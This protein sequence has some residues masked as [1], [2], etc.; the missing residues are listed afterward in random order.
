MASIIRIKRSAVSG[1]PAVLA[2][3]ELAYSSLSD[4]GSNGGDRL[5]IGT[6]TE[7]NGNAV[8]HVIIGGKYF[9]D[10]VDAATNSN[11]NSTLV[12]RDAS[13]N[14]S[15]G[16][17]TANL[18]GNAST[19]TAWETS[20]SITLSGDVTGTVSGVN[21][22]G[23]ISISTTIAADSVA[24]G[25]DTTGQYASTV[26]VS[27]NGLSATTPNA[28]DS[29]AYTITSNAT[30]ANT[31]NTIVFR[32]ASG[33]FTAGTITAALNGNATTVTNGVYTTDTGSVTN[34]MLAGS[35]SDSKLS[36]ITTAGKVANSATTATNSNTAST[37]VARDASGNFAAGT[38]TATFS[39]SLTGNADTASAWVTA[40][41]L[42]LTGDASATLTGVN[43]SGNVSATLTLATVNSNTGTFGSATAIPVITVNGKGLITAVSTTSIDNIPTTLSIA[44]TSGTD[45]VN[46]IN[47]T[48]TF[49]GGTGVTTAVTNNQVSIAI[50]QAVGTTDNVTFNNVSASGN[51]TVSGNLT[52]N[53]TTTTVSSTVISIADPIFTLGG[54]TAPST[55]D[56]KDRGIEFRWHNGTAAKVGFF[57]FDDSTGYLTFIPDA[58]NTTEVFSGSLGDIQAANFRGALIGNADTATTWATAR[59]LSLT[60][61]ATATLT[62]VNGSAN[63]SAALTLATVNSNTGS[64]GSGTSVPVV[65]VNAK[66]LV[67]AVTTSSVPT[68][69]YSVLGLASFDQT[70]FTVTSGAVTI[71]EVTGGSY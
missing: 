24:L 21:G 41:D 1:N 10:I 7:T 18:T 42:S 30:S 67:T 31:A 37:I 46:L 19:A 4:N 9:T 17:I 40:R 50:G 20:R 15:A 28:D 14:F 66:G 55:D 45:T 8:N 16:M 36:T 6:G 47:D 3:G 60:G 54:T 13:G 56:G 12:K 59:D 58:T 5:Y 62:G 32:D 11:T 61:D 25:T 69:T 68:A 27:G 51:V 38:I 53:G 64:F 70:Q 34:T 43:G 52:V 44:G 35:I 26:A 57:G 65:T 22:T 48:L 39:G 71:N 49:A 33:N 63:V 23:N 29:T 2:A